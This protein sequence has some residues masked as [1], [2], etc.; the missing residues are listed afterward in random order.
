M[1]HHFGIATPAFH[2]AVKYLESWNTLQSRQLFETMLRSWLRSASMFSVIILATAGRWLSAVRVRF[3]ILIPHPPGVP[4]FEGRVVWRGQGRGRR[5][6]QGVGV[7]HG[8]NGT[9]S[10]PISAG[11]T[12][13]PCLRVPGGPRQRHVALTWTIRNQSWLLNV[14]WLS[15]QRCDWY[16]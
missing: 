12:G 13:L 10:N 5:T 6:R 4:L 14:H 2:Y 11:T 7:V 16:G 8:S 9:S 15:L 3:A 1:P